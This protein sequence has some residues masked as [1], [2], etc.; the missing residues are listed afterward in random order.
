MSQLVQA[1]V[2]GNGAI[3]TNVCLLPLY[4]GL[5]AFL[6][7]TSGGDGRARRATPWLG[8]VVLAGILTLMTVVGFVLY[9]LQRSF[10]PLLEVLL[11]VIYAAVIVLGLVMLMGVNPFTRVATLRSPVF[12][13]P[14]ATAYAYGLLLGPM[15]LPCT[16]P[17]VVSAFLVGAGSVAV[18]TDGLLYFLAFGLGFGWP[19]V[20]LPLLAAPLQRRGV[21]WLT[22]RHGLLTRV[23]G[24][25]L[26]A[27]GA[28]GVWTEVLPNV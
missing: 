4:P 10:G 8:L 12:R 7:G 11:P 20:L 28:F 1:F 19:L 25:L 23:S 9:V 14:F 22:R 6:A 5:I 15:T 3:L 24:A 2:L 27:I 17:I 26:V 18:L 21:G 16:G 13:N